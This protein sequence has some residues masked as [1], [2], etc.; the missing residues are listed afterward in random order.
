M[1][2]EDLDTFWGFVGAWTWRL[3]WSW[4]SW[5]VWGW[6]GGWGCDFDVVDCDGVG[7]PVVGW[8]SG[9]G[10]VLEPS[11]AGMLQGGV[12]MRGEV[13]GYVEGLELLV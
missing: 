6:F 10:L 5:Q 9:L 12:G 13:E 11:L 8:D 7:G 2:I 1:E 4:R 3:F